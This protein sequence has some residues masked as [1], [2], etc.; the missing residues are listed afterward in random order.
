MTS[1][2]DL[3]TLK[4]MGA[5]AFAAS[6]W[7]MA[8]PVHPTEEEVATIRSAA[9]GES[10]MTDRAIRE[11]VIR[12]NVANAKRWRAWLA[13]RFPAVSFIAPWIAAIDG[14]GD[15]DL[16]PEQR[17]RGLRDCCRTISVCDGL[18][19]VGGRISRGMTEERE[20]ARRSLDLT[21]VGRTPPVDSW[22]DFRKKWAGVVADQPPP[23]VRPD[24]IPVWE[25]VIADF[26][27]RYEDA[28]DGI[29]EVGKASAFRVVADMRE[30]D[31]LGRERYG[32]P[33][34]VN[35]GRDQLV[36]AYQEA[37]DKAVYLRAAWLEGAETRY[38][39]YQ[40]LDDI[41]KIRMMIDAREASR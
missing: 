28:F 30:R 29:E 20:Y 6:L 22:D 18:V 11:L 10:A 4:D 39:Y 14:G 36:D 9:L 38:L 26:R 3:L 41:M 7:Y 2:M 17:A 1:V 40:E 33:L 8:H 34:T 32:T 27:T 19:L 37:L 23:T 35:N 15:D 24:L 21:Q 13:S 5:E 12:S 16:D 31:R 25:N